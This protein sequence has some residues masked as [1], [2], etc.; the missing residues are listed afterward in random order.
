[1]I[2]GYD[3]LKK[4]Y[5]NFDEELRTPNGLDLRLG[6]V[7]ELSE[8]APSYGIYKDKKFIPEHIE[9]MP[10]DLPRNGKKGW[11]L[12]PQRPYILEVDRQ[13]KI[14]NDSMQLYHP[15]SSL[16]RSATNVFTAVGDAGYNGK[17]AFL[18]INFHSRPFIMEKGV[19]F[20]QLIDFDVRGASI[21][22]DGDFQEEEDES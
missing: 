10:E 4:I 1:M 6:K 21:A 8:D 14:S 16:L 18:F 20:V 15:R 7:Y 11:K 22:Y 9:L 19:P 13:I 2:N 3:V 12:Q 17:L 5:P